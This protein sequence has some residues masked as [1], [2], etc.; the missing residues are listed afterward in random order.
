[1]E[2]MCV[3]REVFMILGR[4]YDYRWLELNQE[5]WPKLQAQGVSW[6]KMKEVL[7]RMISAELV[8]T[9]ERLVECNRR[10]L[11]YRLSELGWQELR[12]IT[13]KSK[14]KESYADATSFCGEKECC[15]KA[16]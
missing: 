2:V 4:R 15:S 6:V 1:M 5:I 10:A 3:C 9:Q 7:A 13:E 8:I 16:A 14:G 12:K 11:F